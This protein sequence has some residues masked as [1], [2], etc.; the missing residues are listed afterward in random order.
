MSLLFS[1]FSASSDIGT[2]LL[3]S[4]IT[5]ER[6]SQTESHEAASLLPALPTVEAALSLTKERTVE[7]WNAD[8]AARTSLMCGMTS[9]AS[10]TRRQYSFVVETC[11]DSCLPRY[12][13]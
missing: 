6:N 1:A 4:W 11:R 12:R 13:S 10:C 9:W 7:S 5:C 2:I 8:F 3:A